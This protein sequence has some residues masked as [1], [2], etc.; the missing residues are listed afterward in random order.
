V[1]DYI[2]MMKIGGLDW[3]WKKLTLTRRMLR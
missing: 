3:F 1:N 2:P